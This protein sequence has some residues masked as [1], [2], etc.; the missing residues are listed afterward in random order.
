MKRTRRI[1]LLCAV[2]AGFSLFA[3]CGPV[4]SGSD[5]HDAGNSGSQDT[6]SVSTDSSDSG[7]SDSE[8]SES[9]SSH[10]HTAG[11][12]WYADGN[13]HWH[14]CADP[15]C[16]EILD[17]AAHVFG[18]EIPAT[19]PDCAAEKNGEA[20]HYKC[21]VC[22]KLFVKEGDVYVEKTQ[23]ELEIPY[24][25]TEGTPEWTEKDGK[26]Y[27]TV[28]CSV[29]GDI[30][31][32]EE[33]VRLTF[34]NCEVEPV[35]AVKGGAA[36]VE[37]PVRDGYTFVEWRTAENWGVDG[38]ECD[39]N[40]D[41]VTEDMQLYA[42][43]AKDDVDYVQGLFDTIALV[44][45]LDL[46]TANVADYFKYPATIDTYRSWFSEYELANIRTEDVSEKLAQMK[47]ACGTYTGTVY[48]FTPT[49]ESTHE[50]LAEMVKGY[51]LYDGEWLHNWGNG[52]MG[53][54]ANIVDDVLDADFPIYFNT[55]RGYIVEDGN[56]TI[57]AAN[58]E[59]YTVIPDYRFVL[60]PTNFAYICE[61]YGYAVL[62]LAY[63]YDC[64]LTLYGKSW[65]V[66]S[67]SQMVLIVDS[68]KNLTFNNEYVTTLSDDVYNGVDSSEDLVNDPVGL[69]FQITRATA[70]GTYDRVSISNVLGAYSLPLIEK[71]LLANVASYVVCTNNGTIVTLNGNNNYPVGEYVADSTGYALGT[72]TYEFPRFSIGAEGYIQFGFRLRDDRGIVV[73]M[74]ETVLFTQTAA[75][76]IVLIRINGDGTLT[77]NGSVVPGLTVSA[78]VLTGEAPAVITLVGNGSWT[79]VCITRNIMGADAEYL[80]APQRITGIQQTSVVIYGED[81][82]EPGKETT[83]GSSDSS[84]DLAVT[85]GWYRIGIN[86]MTS[87][88]FKLVP[89]AIPENG[90]AVFRIAFSNAVTLKIGD[91]VIYEYTT[92]REVLEITVFGDGTLAINGEKVIGITLSAAVLAGSESFTMTVG[93]STNTAFCNF[94]INTNMYVY[95]S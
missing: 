72:A 10:E 20:A 40:L 25:H 5:S 67:G 26:W 4:S 87:A 47:E 23:A 31:R 89:T 73:K 29:C 19:V 46:E 64:T 65:E 9:T 88:T 33:G 41:A 92:A 76:D 79:N 54:Q 91:V 58:T 86:Q 95:E 17:K 81:A 84:G 24:S 11:T 45:L 1:L 8:S 14:I 28:K 39:V 32:E 2:L 77:V 34:F 42:V 49:S 94:Y 50:E 85:D 66:P 22:E 55:Q 15:D 3:A 53:P 43:W 48:A 82:A 93:Q 12:E 75:D 37:T 13:E 78:D 38:G 27:N 6:E 16:G 7:G 74:G 30:L 60:R 83:M 63:N 90:K 62:K 35:F 69:T 51:Y 61:M 21:S 36:E 52:G 18:E 71:T 80:P 44:N 68:D 70:Q 57:G 59:G 56:V